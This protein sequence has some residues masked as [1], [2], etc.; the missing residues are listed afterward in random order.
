MEEIEVYF[1]ELSE[2]LQKQI[3]E[4]YNKSVEEVERDNNWDTF[5][6]TTIIIG[7]DE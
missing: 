5:P 1:S 7:D 4:M 6:I 3:A 2:E